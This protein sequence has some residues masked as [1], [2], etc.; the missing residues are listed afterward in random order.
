M[1]QAWATWHLT[2][3]NP[4]NFSLSEGTHNTLEILG[5]ARN[6]RDDYPLHSVNHL[7][8]FHAESYWQVYILMKVFTL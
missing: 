4:F 6:F 7:P 5:L 3:M 8:L 1:R 2:N